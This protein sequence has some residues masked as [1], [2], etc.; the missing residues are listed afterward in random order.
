M[1][2]GKADKHDTS[3]IDT[4][5]EH[6]DRRRNLEMLAA[7]NAANGATRANLFK[8]GGVAALLT[9]LGV[10]AAC[11]GL[12][13]IIPPKIHETLRELPGRIHETVKVVEKEVIKEVPGPE[14]VVTKEV[15]GPTVY[16]TKKQ[17][18]FISQPDYQ[19]AEQKGRIIKSTDGYSVYFDNGTSFQPV[20]D[21]RALDTDALVGDFGYCS[22]IP[23]KVD[24]FRCFAIH[25]DKVMELPWKDR[26]ATI[27]PATAAAVPG[28]SAKEEAFIDQPEYKSAEYKGRLVADARGYIT[29]DNG[30][31]FL[32]RESGDRYVTA[33]YVGDYAF[34]NF[35]TG[36]ASTYKCLAMHNGKLIDL[37]ASLSKGRAS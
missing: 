22:P 35:V 6:F 21:K 37:E 12:S 31:S 26:V 29:F 17:E 7:S 14:R 10:G 8:W 32:P 2:I 9:G 20:N 3:D 23:G 11:Y 25:S 33:P 24:R 4:L 36:T 30:K 16:I 34:C 15:P 18:Q 19:A 13:F 5:D 28:S 1:D 27:D